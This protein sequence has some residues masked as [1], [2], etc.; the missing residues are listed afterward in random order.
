MVASVFAC[1][2]SLEK[3]LFFGARIEALLSK[4]KG[5]LPGPA[6]ER[7]RKHGTCGR[8]VARGVGVEAQGNRGWKQGGSSFLRTVSGG[9]ARITN[10]VNSVRA[11][12]VFAIRRDQK[13]L[14]IKLG[15]IGGGGND[16]RNKRYKRDATYGRVEAERRGGSKGGRT[17][18]RGL[19]VED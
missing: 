10:R 1:I 3:A 7:G 15:T 5:L 9:K 12:Y 16:E 8:E 19:N 18:R 17:E 14:I 13:K 6:R 4:C 2:L 11:N